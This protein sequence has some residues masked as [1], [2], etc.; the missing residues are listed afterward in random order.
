MRE[1]LIPTRSAR[2]CVRDHD[3]DGRPVILVHG[4][5]GTAY[6]FVSLRPQ[7]AQHRVIE[8][9]QRGHGRSTGDS[10][11][12]RDAISDLEA[13]VEHLQLPDAAI[14]G[15][16]FGG[17]V[18]ASYAE[19]HPE[20]CAVVNVDGYGLGG[21]A[22]YMRI[23]A[24]AERRLD[25]LRAFRR[26][27]V[28]RTLT[29]EELD[30]RLVCAARSAE[31]SGRS[32]DEARAAVLRKFRRLSSGE[33]EKLPPRTIAEAVVAATD[34]VDVLSLYP[35][36]ECPLLTVLALQP[37]GPPRPDLSW[38]PDFHAAQIAGLRRELH[39]L[40]AVHANLELVEVDAQHVRLLDR[41]DVAASIR[42]FIARH[43]LQLGRGA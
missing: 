34:A 13:V 10:W 37:D 25:D 33:W 22:R 17:M 20:A 21:L 18:A 26:S 32:P 42:D 4:Y 29:E 12:W 15:F 16:S 31:H 8:L 36:I 1:L 23:D 35:R 11:S 38:A 6:D 41:G 7:L 27:R 9:E 2:L 19:A 40:A 43:A 39:R 5:P 3:G 28:G 14:V 24:Q 30:A